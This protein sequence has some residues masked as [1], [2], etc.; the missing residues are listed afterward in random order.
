MLIQYVHESGGKIG[1]KEEKKK[2][3]SAV[4]GG[5]L[6]CFFRQV[7]L[8]FVIWGENGGWEENKEENVKN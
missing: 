4:H 8:A 7:W 2:K 6:F 1:N 5:K 3:T